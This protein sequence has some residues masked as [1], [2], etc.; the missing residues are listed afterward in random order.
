M[1]TLS[2]PRR[3]RRRAIVFVCAFIPALA[4]SLAYV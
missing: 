1:E 4:I 2:P 3:S